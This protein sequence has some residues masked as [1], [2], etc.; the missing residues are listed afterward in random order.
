[1]AEEG[2]SAIPLKLEDVNEG[3]PVTLLGWH[4]SS[5]AIKDET[6][7]QNHWRWEVAM[8]NFHI[9]DVDKSYPFVFMSDFNYPPSEVSNAIKNIF[10]Y[11][12]IIQKTGIKNPL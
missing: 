9:T 8:R 10:S 4:D 11:N 3:L 2:V 1:M 6:R 5:N 7:F 12:Y